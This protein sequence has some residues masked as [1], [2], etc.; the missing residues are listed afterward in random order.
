[1][2]KYF[3][4]QTAAGMT[5]YMH[6]GMYVANDYELNKHTHTHPLHVSRSDQS[7]SNNA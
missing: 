4:V 1:M 5:I 2:A 6:G 7:D 3:Y